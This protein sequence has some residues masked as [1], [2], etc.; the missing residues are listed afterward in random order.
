MYWDKNPIDLVCSG[1]LQRRGTMVSD[2]LAQPVLQGEVARQAIISQAGALRYA[3]LPATD[4][5]L[6]TNLGKPQRLNGSPL[7][8]KQA[9]THRGRLDGSVR[10]VYTDGWISPWWWGFHSLD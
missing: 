1:K 3:F 9:K 2:T 5:R 7:L 10:H 4:Q 8:R 6:G